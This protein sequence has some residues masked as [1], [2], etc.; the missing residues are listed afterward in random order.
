MEES[1]NGTIR[2]LFSRHSCMHCTDAASEFAL[3]EL[4][5]IISMVSFPMIKIS[6]LAAAIVASIAPLMFL[7]W[8]PAELAV[9]VR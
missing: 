5:I 3:Q 9:S 6:V 8:M 2:W 7:T 4:S 1:E